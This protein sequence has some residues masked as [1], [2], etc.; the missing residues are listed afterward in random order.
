MEETVQT[1]PVS[2]FGRKISSI[3]DTYLSEYV[4]G[5][6]YYLAFSDPHEQIYIDRKIC[7]CLHFKVS[8]NMSNMSCHCFYDMQSIMCTSVPCFDH[9]WKAQV[10]HMM[11]MSLSERK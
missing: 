9:M 10:Q 5:D 7:A 8:C 1:H 4:F 2:G 3:L 6:I 11:S